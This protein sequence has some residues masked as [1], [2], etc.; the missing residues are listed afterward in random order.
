MMSLFNVDSLKAKTSL[1]GFIKLELKPRVLTKQKRQ[2][3]FLASSFCSPV[4]LNHS[5]P[6]SSLLQINTDLLISKVCYYSL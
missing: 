2:F 4:V 5:L 3:R 1:E 6:R